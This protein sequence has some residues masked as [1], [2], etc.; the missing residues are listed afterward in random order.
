MKK[1]VV[2]FF[3]V[4]TSGMMQAQTEVVDTIYYHYY[5]E[6]PTGGGASSNHEL[7]SGQM[8]EGDH[9]T[10]EERTLP[11]EISRYQPLYD[12]L[13]GAEMGL[14]EGSL[15]GSIELNIT[16]K[17]LRLADAGLEVNGEHLFLY[18]EVDVTDLKT[19]T[20][21]SPEESFYFLNGKG[22]YL[23]IPVTPK[24]IAFCVMNGIDISQGISFAY[25]L[26]NPD[27]SEVWS[28]DGLT[29]E[30]DNTVNPW[31]IT[32]RLVHFS[33]FGGGGKTLATDVQPNSIV[34]DQF[35]LL[36][37]YPN[38]FNPSTIIRYN[39]PESGTV[40]LK[41]YNSLG[42]ELSILESGYKSAGEHTVEFNSK[43]LSTGTYFY[44]INF[45]GK[46]LTRKMLLI[47]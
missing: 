25:L 34:P 35:T 30:L 6:Y 24:F 21:Y 12:A 28:A 31:M 11:S 8:K 37:N 40:S 42:K 36:Q 1:L 4:L 46:M 32:L 22:A 43:N 14:E 38:P 39:L 18:M 23:K 45:N 9:F 16:I 5:I 44:T 33:K 10:L 3:L 26:Q 27:G 29:W 20:W 41:I 15:N 47:K 13:V 7:F 19:G 2:L 17:R